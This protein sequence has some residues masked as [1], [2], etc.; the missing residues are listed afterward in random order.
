MTA[1]PHGPLWCWSLL[2]E[3]AVFFSQQPL[4]WEGAAPG[5]A[6]VPAFGVAGGVGGGD[7]LA[8][9]RRAGAAV[10]VRSWSHRDHARPI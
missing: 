10:A 3:D 8:R 9:G 6:P 1:I 4:V 2:G 5:M 7:G